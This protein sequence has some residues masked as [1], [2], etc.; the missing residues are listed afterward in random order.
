MNDGKLAA[1]AALAIRNMLIGLA[2]TSSAY[3][4]LMV[5][6]AAGM[7]GVDIQPRAFSAAL[8]ECRIIVW[9]LDLFNLAIDGK[10]SFIGT[11]LPAETDLTPEFWWFNEFSAESDQREGLPPD[12]ALDALLLI[13]GRGIVLAYFG[14][15]GQRDPVPYLR[16]VPLDG[17]WIMALRAFMK[18]KIAALQAVTL[19]RGTRRRAQRAG[20]T[21]PDIRV[22]HLRQREPGNSNSESSREYH[23]RW[24]T[25][26]HWRRLP[27]ALKQDSKITG[28]RKGDE[29][30]FVSA[31]IKGPVGAPL[32]QPRESVYVV[33]R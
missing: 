18:L 5:E 28:A 33:A 6:R 21:L 1:E 32:L 13:P 8:R 14:G 11:A 2:G 19:P 9:E 29:V 7:E 24:I 17:T 16:V 31:Y 20:E 3:S 12:A 25:T 23:H 4:D 27:E 30:T 10:E 26:G 15:V 22:V